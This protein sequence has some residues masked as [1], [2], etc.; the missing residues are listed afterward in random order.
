VGLANATLPFITALAGKGL[1][2]AMHDDAHLRNGLNIHKGQ[3]TEPNVASALGF[4]YVPAHTAL[5]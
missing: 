2:K 4:D 1:I 3:V 5:E